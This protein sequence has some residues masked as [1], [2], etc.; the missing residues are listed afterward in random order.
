MVEE[1]ERLERDRKGIVAVEI[2]TAKP[3]DQKYR[4]NLRVK[5]EEGTGNKVEL[6]ITE[7]ENLIGGI[8]ARVGGTIYDGSIEHQLERIQRKLEEE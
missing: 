5:L 1:F 6:Q 4:D 3:L 8:V 2:A 7:N